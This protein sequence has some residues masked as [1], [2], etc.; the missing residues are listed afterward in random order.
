MLVLDRGRRG[1]P[2]FPSLVLASLML[3]ALAGCRAPIRHDVVLITIDTLRPDHLGFLG[4]PRD[5]APYLS[6]LA[7]GSVVFRRAFS[8]STWTAP[9]TASL[10]TS[11]HPQDHGVRSGFFVDRKRAS[12]AGATAIRL[13]RLPDSMPTLPEF[14]HD[15]GYE[16]FGITAN[17]NVGPEIGFDRGFDHFARLHRLE[18]RSSAGAE[19]YDVAAD[20]LDQTDLAAEH[21]TV[22]REL[23]SRLQAAFAGARPAAT[24][25]GDRSTEVPLD[26]EKL[27]TLRSL[28]YVD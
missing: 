5:T 14:F 27:E 13:P 11:R 8:T 17:V 18:R 21:P 26:A 16:T 20:P 12:P 6:S 7:R 24:T 1:A 23:A 22:V 10:L 2:F 25:G 15:H 3:P 4:Y 9:A 19:L 28:G